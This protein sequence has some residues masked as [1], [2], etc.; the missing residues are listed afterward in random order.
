MQ[1]LVKDFASRDT[2]R[3]GGRADEGHEFVA[4]PNQFM[5]SDRRKQVNAAELP[6]RDCRLVLQSCVMLRLA[7]FT[8]LP[9]SRSGIAAY[10]AELLPRLSALYRID[11]FMDPAAPAPQVDPG[12]PVFPSRDFLWRHGNQPYDLV[13]Y[14]LGNATCHDYMWPYLVRFPGLVVLHDGQL[15]QARSKALLTSRRRDDYRAEF[16]F[17]HPDANPG[18]AEIVIAALGGSLYFLW[19]MLRVPIESS[20]L[21]ACHS[22]WLAAQLRSQFAHQEFRVIEMGVGDLTSDLGP[23]TATLHLWDRRSLDRWQDTGHRTPD[24]GPPTSDLGPRTATLHPWDRR[25]LDR[26]QDAS[27][28]ARHLIPAG[29]IVFAAYGMLTPE[30]RLTQ[31]FRA[32]RSVLPYAPDAHVLLVGQP[33]DYYDVEADAR[34]I[35]VADRVTV[36]GYVTDEELPAYLAA[37]D[38][39]LCLRWPTSRETSASWLRC[40]A[41]GKPTV[42]TD[43]VHTTSVPA[44]DPRTWTALEAAPRGS[45]SSP[46]PELAEG[47]PSDVEPR[48]A[49]LH[50]WDR[51][52]LDRWQDTGL[53]TSDDAPA[54]VAIDMVDEQ[55]SL[56]LAMR[57]LARDE[58]LRNELG[59]RAREYWAR[60]HTPERM[61][62]DYR[63]AIEAALRRPAP[64]RSHLPAHLLPD[65]TDLIKSILGQFGLSME[66]LGWGKDG[67]S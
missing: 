66:T 38:V 1:F 18:I 35:G 17:C 55:H 12:V 39:C 2:R 56:G 67:S 45:T 3:R 28:L 44:L 57:R 50:P 30:K 19:P 43:L 52:S 32:L 58:P 27:V 54:C 53:R 47:R 7:W 63:Q 33:V 51:R 64:D 4:N 29:R 37:A 65:G 34:A 59:R 41:A 6:A 15:H 5:L 9:P 42:I 40:L 49:T 22:P 21:V 14:Q 16:A 13:V 23:R 25:S 48:T 20:R 61:A 26:W 60:H 36:T 8:P 46:R 10:S 62:D 24:A 11:A 31:I